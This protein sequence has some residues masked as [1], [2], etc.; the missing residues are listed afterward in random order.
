MISQQSCKD[1]ERSKEK[2][3]IYISTT[4]STTEDAHARDEV[5]QRNLA[6]ARGMTDPFEWLTDDE[7]MLRALCLTNRLA[8]E[9]YDRQGLLAALTPFIQTFIERQR[10][11]GTDFYLKGR[12]DTKRHFAAWL[13]K[14]LSI[15]QKETTDYANHFTTF[16]YDR[17]RQQ[18]LEECARAV[19]AGIAAG[20]AG[21]GFA[22]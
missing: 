12:I 10:A 3:R 5:E 21:L 14:Y 15:K 19:E 4:A 18:Q 17:R 20:Q 7:E 9:T 2:E 6:D 13:P 8:P 16:T 11:A 22:L 1:K